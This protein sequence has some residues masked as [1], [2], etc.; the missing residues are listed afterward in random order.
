VGRGHGG[1]RPLTVFQGGN[2]FPY[3]FAKIHV[4]RRLTVS[5]AYL[6]EDNYDMV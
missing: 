4:K 5:S 3:Y 1:R 2:A 6:L